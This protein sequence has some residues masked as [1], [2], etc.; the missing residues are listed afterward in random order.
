MRRKPTILLCFLLVFLS[1]G[2]AVTY[3]QLR[4]DPRPTFAEIDSFL[5]HSAAS[6]E[7][8]FSGKEPSRSHSSAGPAWWNKLGLPKSTYLL[9][10]YH[11]H[12]RLTAEH[13]VVSLWLENGEVRNIHFNG[14][15]LNS[16]MFKEIT[17]R[18]FPGI[19][20][21]PRIKP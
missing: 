5:R 19:I 21:P 18:K 9:D 20:N 17:F 4:K 10:V 16:A 1:I 6:G 7:W 8:E 14:E 15:A 12:N 3:H 13:V 11:F 2:G